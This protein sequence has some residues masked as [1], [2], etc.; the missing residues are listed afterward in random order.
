MNHQTLK[1][2]SSRGWP[3]C[4]TDRKRAGFS[5]VDLTLTM[6]ILGILTATAAPRLSGAM[7]W[8]RADGAARRIEADLN[9]VRE[10]ARSTNS[11]CSLVFS[12]ISPK[13]TTTGVLEINNSGNSYAVDLGA[14]GYPVTVTANINGGT[15]ITYSETGFP[16]AGSPL[17]A[18]T[19]GT[20]TITSGKQ[21]RTVTIDPIT[22]KA[23]RS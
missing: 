4:A 21:T 14:L 16:Q 11:A 12:A 2:G 9:Y 18:L 17:S 23:H 6:L 7:T 10:Q 22:G 8:Y 1:D 20:I 3:F 13:Y 19:L 5:L 15:S